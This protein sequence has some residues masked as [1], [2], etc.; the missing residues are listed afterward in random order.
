MF[1]F[2]YNPLNESI[3]ETEMKNMITLIALILI[4]AFTGNAKA[5]IQTVTGEL[6]NEG[7]EIAIY[8]KYGR[9]ELHS[10]LSDINDCFEGEYII[11]SEPKGAALFKLVATVFCR[12]KGKDL[13]GFGDKGNAFEEKSKSM[14]PMVYTPVCGMIAGAPKTFGNMCELNNAGA[15]K[16]FLGNCQNAL[17]SGIRGHRR[18][19]SSL[20]YFK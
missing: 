15:K 10:E 12:G 7:G 17:T 18:I 13:G 1:I 19:D 3:R 6:V 4:V 8:S 16:L 14:C 20:I 11:T 9:L 5:E 2:H